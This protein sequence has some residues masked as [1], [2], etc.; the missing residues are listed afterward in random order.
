MAASSLKE[1]PADEFPD[2]AE[3]IRQHMDPSPGHV[4]AFASGSI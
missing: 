4:G 3:H 1:F 2:L